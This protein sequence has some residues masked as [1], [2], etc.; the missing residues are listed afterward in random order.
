[1]SR[2]EKIKN[3]TIGMVA[4]SEEEVKW[5]QGKGFVKRW[6]EDGSGWWLEKKL[7]HPVLSK[8]TLNVDR[9][10]GTGTPMLFLDAQGVEGENF[11]HLWEKPYSRLV[12]AEVMKGLGLC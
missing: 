6:L 5:L 7:R 9:H 10:Y 11:M 8:P 1:M 2:P 12:L 4:L 3:D